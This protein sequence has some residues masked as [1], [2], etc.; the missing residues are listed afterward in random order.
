MTS[1]PCSSTSKWYS[2]DKTFVQKFLEFYVKKKADK[3]ILTMFSREVS[4]VD[5]MNEII[6]RSQ[7]QKSLE[8]P[9]RHLQYLIF[10]GEITAGDPIHPS[11]TKR[12]EK[13]GENGWMVVSSFG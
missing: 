5:S 2:K 4:R 12:L 6:G 7:A 8:T 3:D 11:F 1:S 9:S 10:E 13:F